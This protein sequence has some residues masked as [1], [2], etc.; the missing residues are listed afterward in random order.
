M[1]LPEEDIKNQ[2]KNVFKE[3]TS[4]EFIINFINFLKKVILFTIIKNNI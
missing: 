4:P 3:K 2:L 1:Q